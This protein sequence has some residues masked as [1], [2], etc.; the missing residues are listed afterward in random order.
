MKELEAAVGRAR[1][2]GLES[3]VTAR[4]E[5]MAHEGLVERIWAGEPAVWGGT[6]ESPELADRLGWLGLPDSMG[7]M[8]PE[9]VDFAEG[10]RGQARHVVLCGMG[11][12]SLA[13]EVF[14]RT[15]GPQAGFPSFTML[16]STAPAAVRAAAPD[17]SDSLF[18]VSSKSGTTL[19]TMSF[20]HYFWELTGRSGSR[21]VAITDPQ[22][23]L[24]RL[25]VDQHF[26]GVF[27]GHPEVGG[28]FSALSVF[29]LVPAAL[30]G[31][32][33]ATI[34]ERACSMAEK[35]RAAPA[36]NPGARLGAILG[37]A[38]LAG[39]DKLT[40]VLSPSL[41]PFG[42]W[43]EQLI[44]ESTGKMGKGILPVVVDRVFDAD[45]YGSDRV[46]VA[47][48]HAGEEAA[49]VD[50][51]AALASRGHPVVHLTLA[52]DE[53][54][55]AEFFRWEFATAVACALIDVNPF[56]QPN[57]AESKA[58]TKAVLEGDEEIGEPDPPSALEALL[59]GVRRGHYLA[60]ML[61]S[62][63]N[64]VTDERLRSVRERLE[65]GL[66]VATTVGYGPRFLHST[67]QLHKGGPPTGNF[68]QV[69]DRPA[70]DLDVPGMPYTFGRLLGA[71]AE[72][73]F[74]ALQRRRRPV[75]RIGD[76]ELLEH[77]V[78]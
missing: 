21:F 38:A 4:L 9:L 29:G 65:R 17:P 37:E 61:Y 31:I 41:G 13:P 12:S 10:Q 6:A 19:E 28:R 32:D 46:F 2:A 68:V 25:A 7:Q 44:A 18:V 24:E 69:F 34:V 14:W 75:V 3:A 70:E 53:D 5:R 49:S 33:V 73:D 57:V 72:G 77:A 40:L 39:R 64:R 62:A 15:F 16:D 51:L 47:I 76:L 50:G 22:G 54:L 74:R 36:E 66:G 56:D 55:G 1:L 23:A 71:Q 63:P 42:L 59:A 78:G 11:G 48:T 35:C 8:A 45:A 52:A 27:S 58:D 43:A 60:I 26:L 30:V 67:G 20:H